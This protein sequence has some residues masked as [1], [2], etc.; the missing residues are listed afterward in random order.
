MTSEDFFNIF[1]YFWPNVR[2][3]TGHSIHLLTGETGINEHVNLIAPDRESQISLES[4]SSWSSI[5][6]KKEIN[7]GTD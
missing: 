6:R 3:N 2:L 4:G 5:R 1:F 7:N